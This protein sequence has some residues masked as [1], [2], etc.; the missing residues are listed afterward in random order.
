M[1]SRPSYLFENFSSKHVIRQKIMEHDDSCLDASTV[2]TYEE[3]TKN[4]TSKPKFL[5]KRNFKEILIEV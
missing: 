5:I 4:N 2:P 3:F 1:S